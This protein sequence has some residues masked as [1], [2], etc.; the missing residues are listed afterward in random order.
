[1]NI[2]SPTGQN[3]VFTITSDPTWPSIPFLTD[4]VGTHTWKWKVVWGT[5]SQ[6]GIASTPLNQWDAQAVVTNFGG[7]LT[8]TA[9]AGN[10]TAVAVV[11]IKGT[12]PSPSD[13]TQFLASRPN[14]AGFDK[15]LIQESHC[16]HFNLAG[17]PIKSFDNGYG[18][19]QLTTPTPSFEQVWNWK[20][21]IAGGLDLFAEK[22]AAAV[23]YLSQSGR[24]YTDNQVTYESVCRWNG[25][26][27]HEWDN[28]KSL[29]VRHPNILCD[30]TT[31]NIGWDMTDAE[32]TGK[33]E[34]QLHQ[35]DR[36]AYGAAPGANAHW[37]YSGVC[38][39]DKVLG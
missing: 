5:F 33:A 4:A 8:V 3:S 22:R 30:S 21:N 32:N 1:M 36:S 15:I 26:S 6:S 35:R 29:W 31:G 9:Q 38:Y 10:E 28:A 23:N 19:C 14:S 12:N 37:K 11:K 27:Y 7:T 24:G 2:T 34:A 18:M 17:E 13:V 39:A 16:R 20:A 25:G